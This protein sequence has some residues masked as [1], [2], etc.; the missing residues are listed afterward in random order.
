MT[1]ET[2]L[3]NIVISNNIIDQGRF[4]DGTTP[5]AYNYD[6]NAWIFGSANIIG[7]NFFSSSAGTDMLNIDDCSCIITN[8]KF[9][10]GSTTINS[11]IR[12]YGPND[13]IITNNLFDQSTVDGGASDA[14]NVL[15]TGLSASS[16]YS[17]NKN[18]II[19]VPI[20]IPGGT[21]TT[22]IAN[23]DIVVDTSLSAV[24]NTFNYLL[25]G[26]NS[27]SLTTF[28]INFNL[29]DALPD[30]VKLLTA[31]IGIFNIVAGVGTLTSGTFSMQAAVDNVVPANF[32]TGLNSILDVKN[33]PG[34]TIGTAGTGGSLD[35]VSATLNL[36]TNYAAVQANT[37]Y[38]TAD[39]S[40]ASDPNNFVTT[41]DKCMSIKVLL[42]NDIN[43]LGSGQLWKLSP[44][45][46]KC[47]W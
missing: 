11:Y 3:A 26:I 42:N 24:F 45:V 2:S 4:S 44:I 34:S 13:Q 8:N 1:L 31:K 28:Y 47:M 38:L 16:T 17:H 25:I 36:F 43:V 5:V 7:N 23:G 6:F 41:K 37:L 35:S 9:V 14:S 32:T 20:A 12:N 18:Q 15:V 10:R 40:T 19:Y 21:F 33:Q 46:V 29:N 39:F 30:S 27:T 22:S